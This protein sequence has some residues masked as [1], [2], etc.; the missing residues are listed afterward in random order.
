MKLI[1]GSFTSYL[2]KLFWP[3]ACTSGTIDYGNPGCTNCGRY[4]VTLA[5]APA[6]GVS[7]TAN[8]TSSGYGGFQP[9]YIQSI[10]AQHAKWLTS[11]EA[12]LL[13]YSQP[14]TNP[15]RALKRPVLPSSI[16]GSMTPYPFGY[17]GPRAV[18]GD[19]FTSWRPSGAVPQ[20]LR[21]DFGAP[22]AMGKVILRWGANYASAYTID[23][24]ND[25]LAWTTQ[26]TKSGGTG[27]VETDTFTAVSARFIR[28]NATAQVGGNLILQ[29]MEVYAQ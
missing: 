3:N 26:F 19:L 2:V 24:S 14:P 7:V 15:N 22:T 16:S 9:S 23:T 8:F 25:G 20:S 11:I 28:L 6:N 21:I 10:S 29:E 4:S 1:S 12:E 27:G 5:T 13:P 18:D 17:E